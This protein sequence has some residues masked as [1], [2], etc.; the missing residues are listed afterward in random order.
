VE[1][2]PFGVVAVTGR[3]A[4]TSRATMLEDAP[5]SS[6]EVGSEPVLLKPAAVRVQPGADSVRF[7][8]IVWLLSRRGKAFVL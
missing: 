1:R 7:L 2:G 3:R 6:W 8:W 4:R 5:V